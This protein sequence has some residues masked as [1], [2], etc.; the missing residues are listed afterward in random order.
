MPGIQSFSSQSGGI[1]VFSGGLPQREGVV[2]QQAQRDP[3]GESTQDAPSQDPQEQRT[4][5]LVDFLPEW[6]SSMQQQMGNAALLE[7]I[8]DRESPPSDQEL[9]EATSVRVDEGEESDFG[10]SGEGKA[11]DW[12]KLRE[13]VAA[14]EAATPGVLLEKTSDVEALEGGEILS[15]TE[16]R[17]DGMIE[18]MTVGNVDVPY[19]K[20]IQRV[21]PSEWSTELAGRVGGDVDP[22]AVDEEGRTVYQED[23]MVLETPMSKHLSWLGDAFPAFKHLDMTKS[24]DIEYGE[25]ETRVRWRVYLSDNETVLQDIGYVHFS[26]CGNSTQVKFHSAHAFTQDYTAGLNWGPLV[27]VRDW[28]VAGQLRDAFT[29]HIE[30]YRE[31]AR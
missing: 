23:R 5:F 2:K 19:E 26:K 1:V 15:A 27:S 16:K 12:R 21:I 11:A 17:D 8:A 4:D 3:G 31:A 6:A 18:E 30:A 9:E 29:A 25:D 13:E 14:F 10:I 24:E 20:F 28:M 7:M 22:L